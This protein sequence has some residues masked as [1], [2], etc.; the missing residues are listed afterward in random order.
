[1]AS[2]CAATGAG[3]TGWKASPAMCSICASRR[4]DAAVANDARARLGE[5]QADL[6]ATKAA[7]MRG[8]LIEA[9]EVVALW[10]RKLRA[11]RNRV[12]TIPARVRD[13]S[14]RQS[15]SLTQELRACLNELAD[16]GGEAR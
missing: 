4:R 10:T 8:E 16:E 5:A 12:L 3:A 2:S 7:K 14:A 9:S 6:A 11:F 1:V 13:L 15:V